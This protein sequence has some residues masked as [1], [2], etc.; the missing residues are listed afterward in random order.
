MSYKRAKEKIS[1][2]IE[3]MATSAQP[4]IQQRLPIAHM[5][6]LGS[7]EP[8]ELPSE[9]QSQFKELQD[10]LTRI[11]GKGGTVSNSRNNK[12]HVNPRSY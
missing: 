8:Y 12:R 3:A 10:K 2:A 4:T 9:V 1:E 7:V 11:P 5:F 6:H